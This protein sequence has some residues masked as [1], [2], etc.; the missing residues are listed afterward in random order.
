VVGLAVLG[1]QAGHL[2][3]YQVRYGAAAQQVQSSGVH[4]YFPTLAKTSLGVVAS[5]LLAG[6]FMIGL[7]R[8]LS[9]R[10]RSSTSAGTS[11]LSLL[12]ILFTVQL[13]CYIGQ[14]VVEALVA[15]LPVDSAPHLVLWGT[16]GQL[17]V[18]A[19]G[20]IA[21]G[22]LARRYEA[23]VDDLRAVLRTGPPSMA[24][25]GVAIP[26]WATSGRALLLSQVAGATL[27]KRGPPPSSRFSSY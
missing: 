6:L 21:L 24:L 18:A 14:E 22:W 11:Y 26:V 7:A 16:L 5:V 19:L 25:L 10:T 23:A 8:V 13:A 12:A 1:S 20:A 17:P 3:A 4:A 9:G 27:G 15:G 2:L